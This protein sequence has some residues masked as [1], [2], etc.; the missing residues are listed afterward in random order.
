[1]RG[2]EI[3]LLDLDLAAAGSTAAAGAADT[4]LTGV[5]AR[6]RLASP[7]LAAPGAAPRPG[8]AASIAAARPNTSA[9]IIARPFPMR[10]KRRE[11][12]ESVRYRIMRRQRCDACECEVDFLQVH[13]AR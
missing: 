9:M 2:S 4:T 6:R 1:M 11:R 8:L 7:G 12:G 13:V 3:R 10:H 5:P